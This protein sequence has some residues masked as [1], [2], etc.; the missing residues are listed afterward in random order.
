MASLKRAIKNSPYL[1]DFKVI[2]NEDAQHLTI[3]NDYMLVKFLIHGDNQRWLSFN[4]SGWTG[5]AYC[6]ELI[7]IMR[8][9]E[10]GSN[11]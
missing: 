5:N 6:E 8:D 3:G 1:K 4:I 7:G 11:D 2:S 10:R 9:L